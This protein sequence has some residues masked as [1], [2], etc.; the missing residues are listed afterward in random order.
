M[1]ALLRL[2]PW[3]E[4]LPAAL[5]GGQQQRTARA[6]ALVKDARLEL[7]D[8]ALAN[9]DCK[10]REELPEA[11]PQLFAGSGATWVYATGEPLEVLM[12]GGHRAALRAGRVVR[13]GPT[14]SVY[15][16][17][18]TLEMGSRPKA[19]VLPVRWRV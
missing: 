10:L 11:L 9:L 16:S 8:E 6:R 12:L 7:S 14:A 18:A 17:P 1:A 5:C 13:F 19:N 3:L 4:R 15:R 2:T